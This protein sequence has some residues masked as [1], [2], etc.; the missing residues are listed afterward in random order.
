MEHTMV[1]T[2]LIREAHKGKGHMVVLWLDLANAYGSIPH[3]LVEVALLKHHMS[4]KI[5][6]LILDYYNNFNMRVTSRPITSDCHWLEKGIITG[7][8]ILVII[9]T[10]A[11][12]M[13]VKSAEVE[14]RRPLT[15]TGVW[16]PSIRALMAT[17]GFL[18]A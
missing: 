15:K 11:M 3:K 8:T 6:D 18:K 13:V 7:C 9:F 17:G 16:Q 1:V 12:N 14:F 5:K 2:Q 10:L 4:S